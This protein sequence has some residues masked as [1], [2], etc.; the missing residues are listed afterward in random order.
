MSESRLSKLKAAARSMTLEERRQW[1]IDIIR[2]YGAT[3]VEARL[4]A[5]AIALVNQEGA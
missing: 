4:V 3:S 2:E 1:R 5:A